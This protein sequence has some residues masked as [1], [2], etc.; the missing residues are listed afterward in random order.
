MTTILPCTLGDVF[1]SPDAA[2][3]LSEYARESAIDGLPAP[4]PCREIY[5]HIEQT[6]ALHLFS[7][8]HDG[9]LIGFLALLVSV[10]PHYSTPLAVTESYFVASEYRY[11]GAGMGLLRAAEEHAAKLGAAGFLVS[12]P[13]AGRLSEILPRTGYRETNRVFFKALA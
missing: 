1:D 8:M 10:N 6:G 7:A 5:A 4:T 3:L 11:T 12:S 13:S 9:K 2:A